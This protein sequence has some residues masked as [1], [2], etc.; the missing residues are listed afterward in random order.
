M[1]EA[2]MAI[3]FPI[4]DCPEVRDIMF[5]EDSLS[6]LEGKLLSLYDSFD[7]AM[8]GR[9]IHTTMRFVYYIGETYRRA[10]E[11]TWAALP[12]SSGKQDGNIPVVDLP[13]RETLAKPLE[14]VQVALVRRTGTEVAYLYP[15]TKIAYE[16]WLAEGRPARTYRGTL[17][18]VD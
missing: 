13:F 2:V 1:Q 6:V 3:E 11:G 10:F 5:T 17:R 12:R 7:A 9:N 8:D 14:A 4:D 18:E 15:R 16:A